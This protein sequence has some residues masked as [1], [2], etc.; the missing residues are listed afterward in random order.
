MDSFE[1]DEQKRLANLQKHGIDFRDV[2]LLTAHPMMVGKA[3]TVTDEERWMATGRMGDILVTMIFTRREDAIRIIS[4][5]SARR[6]ER[7]AY[8]ALLGS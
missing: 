5:R 1:W 2:I 7:K 4:I 6:G 8:Q 3:R